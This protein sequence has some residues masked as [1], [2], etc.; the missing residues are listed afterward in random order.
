VIVNYDCQ[1]EQKLL[2]SACLSLKGE[3]YVENG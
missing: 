2:I 1:F 3:S